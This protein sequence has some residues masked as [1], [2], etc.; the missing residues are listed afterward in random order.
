MIELLKKLGFKTNESKILYIL[1]N[2]KEYTLRE[3][4]IISELRQPEVSIAIKQLNIRGY[5]SCKEVETSMRGRPYKLISLAE[6]PIII[7][8]WIEAD[9][10]NECAEKLAISEKL[11]NLTTL[12]KPHDEGSYNDA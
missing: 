2:G 8:L 5:L 11:R 1:L 6:S 3:L 9:I 10:R 7:L 12:H 4:E